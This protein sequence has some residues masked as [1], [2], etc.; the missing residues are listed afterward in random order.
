[1]N[2]AANSDVNN[3]S[4]R[5]VGTLGPAATRQ[6]RALPVAFLLRLHQTIGNR[7]VAAL[8]APQPAAP[9]L[10]STSATAAT[11]ATAAAKGP[12]RSHRPAWPTRLASAVGLFGIRTKNS[13]RA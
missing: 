10:S 2:N 8:L 4:H 11:A 7:A 1:V 6:P 13:A 5:V 12:T 9:P 3:P